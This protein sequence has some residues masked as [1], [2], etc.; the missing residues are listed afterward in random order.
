MYTTGEIHV[1]VKY[2]LGLLSGTHSLRITP[3]PPPPGPTEEPRAPSIDKVFL[4][5]FRVAFAVCMLLVLVHLHPN[6]IDPV[7]AL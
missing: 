3:A 1:A 7:L 5:D 6:Y 2:F 4:D